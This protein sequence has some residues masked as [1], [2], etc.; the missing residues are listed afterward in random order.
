MEKP[1]FSDNWYRVRSLRP[2]LRPHT[3]LHRQEL[4]GAIWYILED[5]SSSRFHRFSAAAHRVIG[6]MDGRRTVHRIWEEVNTQLGD[7]APVQDDIIQLLGQLHRVDALQTNITPDVE[8]VFRRGE[9]QE[10][11]QRWRQIK[12]PLSLRLPLIDPDRFLARSLPLVRFVFSRPF[13][14]LWIVVVGL[15]AALAASNWGLLVDTARVEA[16]RP[17]NLLLLLLVYPL[18]KLLHELGHAYAAKLH[19]GEVHEIGVMLLVFFPVPYVDASAATVFPERSM[20]MLVGAVGI[21]AELWLAALALFVWLNVQPGWVSSV[22]FNV[23]LIGGVSTLLFNGNPLLRFDGYYVLADA[24]GIP[25]LAQRANQYIAYLV[26][27]YLLGARAARSPVTAEGEAPWFV[28]YAIGSFCYRIF[29]LTVICLFL[30]DTLFFVG[31]VLAVWALYNQL[32]LP[33]VRQLNFLMRDPGLRRSRR[34]AVTG[35]PV[36][37]PTLAL[38]VRVNSDVVPVP[39]RKS[40]FGRVSSRATKQCLHL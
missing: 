26:Q 13:L 36:L 28:F 8:E 21:M 3:R 16:L 30:I 5:R 6:L 23:M 1:L 7:D 12:N 9:E 40:T 20:R 11:Q 31:V 29:L 32:C 25:N 22:C 33:I 35:P 34:R 14:L 19:G 18:V 15:G 24:I 4:R 27:H 10:L 17:G 39:G 2:K 38:A 37:R